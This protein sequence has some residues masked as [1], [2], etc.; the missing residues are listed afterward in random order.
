MKNITKIILFLSFAFPVFSQNSVVPIVYSETLLGGTQNGKWI[1]AEK[2]DVQLTDK[3]EFNIVNFNGIN[4]IGKFFGTKA[5]RGVC[6][7]PRITFDAPEANDTDNPPFLLGANA[8][9]NPVPR[10]P[11]TISLTDK[12]YAKTVADFL[13]TKGI[14]KTKIKLAQAFR[15]DL[16]G[17][18]KDE[19]IITGNYF[20]KAMEGEEIA[21]DGQQS[22]DDYSFVLLRKIVKGKPQNI[23][24]EGDFY[25]TRVLQIGK[26]PIKLM[27]IGES[28]MPSVY[29]ITA[30]ADLNGDG[31]ME[32]VLSVIY[33]EGNR[34]VIFEIKNGKTVKVLES[35]CYV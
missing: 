18:G 7:N 28:P 31:K 8:K 26:Y 12:T 23:L 22:A 13:K 1:T 15:I 24:I 20:K 11:E 32:I 17:D 5:E 9:W 4:K 27:E 16:E 14:S 25:P 34:E 3:T 33:Y 2:T 19:I 35:E 6:E 21:A 30:I 29:E 10:L